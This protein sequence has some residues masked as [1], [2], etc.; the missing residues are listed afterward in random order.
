MSLELNYISFLDQFTQSS[1][2]CSTACLSTAIPFSLPAPN[3]CCCIYTQTRRNR[4]QKK[5]NVKTES[6]MPWEIRL[7]KLVCLTRKLKVV[8]LHATKEG[9]G[10]G[11]RAALCTGRRWVANLTPWKFCRKITL[12]LVLRFE[13]RPVQSVA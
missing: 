12:L 11:S 1:S 7:S 8:A 9:R 6:E 13:P 5:H 10:N 2:S 3:T 4:A